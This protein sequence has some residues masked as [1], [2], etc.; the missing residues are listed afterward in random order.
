MAPGGPCLLQLSRHPWLTRVYQGSHRPDS[1]LVLPRL[2]LLWNP[3][4]LS[5]LVLAHQGHQ[6]D[7]G[8]L[9]YLSPVNPR[10]PLVQSFQEF[11]VVQGILAFLEVLV[12]PIDP[13][14]LWPCFSHGARSGP[15]TPGLPAST[16]ARWSCN[17]LLSS[18]S[19]LPRISFGSGRPGF[20]NLPLLPEVQAYHVVQAIQLNQQVPCDQELP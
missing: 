1:P 17:A 4:S 3:S 11:L 7:S 18:F 8:C 19:L 15:E 16:R 12:G 5:Y 13:S 9:A 20:P 2:L 14:Y 10:A 6:L